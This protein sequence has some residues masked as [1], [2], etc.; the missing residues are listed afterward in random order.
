[1]FQID[2]F[3]QQSNQISESVHDSINQEQQLKKEK[4]CF[5]SVKFSKFRIPRIYAKEFRV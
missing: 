4:L 3:L 2:R 1:M 5:V